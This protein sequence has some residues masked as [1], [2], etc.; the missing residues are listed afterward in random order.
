MNVTCPQFRSTSSGADIQPKTDDL[1][2]TCAFARGDHEE[3]VGEPRGANC[4]VVADVLLKCG[5]HYCWLCYERGRDECNHLVK[6]R[7]RSGTRLVWEKA[8]AP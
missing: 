2:G 8:E 3:E 1:C 6:V 4:E 5:H 7:R